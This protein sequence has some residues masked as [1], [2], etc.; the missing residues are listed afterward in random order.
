ML[1]RLFRFSLTRLVIAGLLIQAIF[2]GPALA[3]KQG[4]ALWYAKASVVRVQKPGRKRKQPPA[5]V[6]QTSL[7]TLQWRVVKRGDGNVKQEIAPVTDFRTNDQLQM[8]VSPNQDGYLYIVHYQ[9]G[10]DGQ[11]LFPAPHINAGLNFVK[12]N[13]EYFVPSRCSNVPDADDCWITMV[14]PAGTENFI[15]VFS[16]DQIT[17]LPNEVSETGRV[18]VKPDIIEELKSLSQQK[19]KEF[20]PVAV[21]GLTISKYGKWVRNTNLKD[22]EELITTISLKHGE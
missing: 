7:L 9:E 20:K 8:A 12:K 14:P 17:K 21:R 3:Q 22:N 19:V 15:V 1:P 18:V 10:Q 11:L 2:T 6:E 16:R 13:Q 5:K 4:A